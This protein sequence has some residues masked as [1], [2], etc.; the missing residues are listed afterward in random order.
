MQGLCTRTSEEDRKMSTWKHCERMVAKLLGGVRT[1]C[2]GESR[3]D[4]EHPRWSVEV[5]HRKDMPKWIDDAYAQSELEKE[6]RVPIVVLHRKGEK[7]DDCYV[8]MKLIDF[9]EI[10][11]EQK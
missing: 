3:R 10:F 4:I 8:L 11:N 7:Y 1:G 9:K 5:K 2:N 6:H